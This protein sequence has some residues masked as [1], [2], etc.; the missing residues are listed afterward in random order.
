[1]DRYEETTLF[2]QLI[3]DIYWQPVKTAQDIC[4]DHLQHIF[5]YFSLGCTVHQINITLQVVHAQSVQYV[6]AVAWWPDG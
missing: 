5:L 3:N 1:M 2:F 6:A 4:T